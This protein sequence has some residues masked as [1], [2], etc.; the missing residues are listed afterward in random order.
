MESY[1]RIRSG[2]ECIWQP[3]PSELKIH[4]NEIH[5]WSIPLDA[6]WDIINDYK[7]ILSSDEQSRAERF[8]FGQ[9]RQRYLSGHIALREIVGKYLHLNPSDLAIIRTPLGKPC[10]APGTDKRH[11]NFSYSQSDNRAL[12]A[13]GIN[14][15]TGIDIEHIRAG[16]DIESMARQ[17]FSLPELEAIKSLPVGKKEYAFFELWTLREAFLKAEGIGIKALNRI[18]IQMFP[19]HLPSFAVYTDFPAAENHWS[20]FRLSPGPEY[21]AA[22]AAAESIKE[23]RFYNFQIP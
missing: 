9:H 1:H 17:L 21:C 10:L 16:M 18:E 3:P 19:D 5:V 20:L 12:L 15:S 22:L 8:R 13:V 6:P 4:E 2:P 14:H 23:I 7:A 11:L